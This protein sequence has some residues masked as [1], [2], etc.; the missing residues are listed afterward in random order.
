MAAWDVYVNNF[1]LS[2]QAYRIDDLPGLRALPDAPFPTSTQAGVDGES[3]GWGRLAAHQFGIS[4]WVD[5]V[6]PATGTITTTA[7]QHF[8]T[9]IDTLNRVFMPPVTQVRYIEP[10]SNTWSAEC[11]RT[12]GVVLEPI[13]LTSCRYK[14]LLEAIGG[15]WQDFNSATTLG[16]YSASVVNTLT[17]LEKGNAAIYDA[18]FRVEGPVTNPS[19]AFGQAGAGTYCTIRYLGTVADGSAWI[20]DAATGG[21][22]VKVGSPVTD[23]SALSG[24]TNVIASTAWWGD[25]A[26]GRLF[27]ICPYVVDGTYKALLTG[28]ATGVNTALRVRARAR[29]V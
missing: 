26:P 3:A 2:S 24:G 25:I 16:P 11:R 5:G 28:S 9:N 23:F 7:E 17:G 21:S 27:E 18:A 13:N 14:V 1:L 8:H 6:D 10:D 19:V 29:R 20:V 12:S 15:S 22:R 4:L